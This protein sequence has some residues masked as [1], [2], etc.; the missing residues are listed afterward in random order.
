MSWH[1][2]LKLQLSYTS[3]GD[4]STD[5][6][7]TTVASVL[8]EYFKSPE[9]TIFWNDDLNVNVD[10]FEKLEGGFFATN[11]D[12]KVRSQS[13]GT[14]CISLQDSYRSCGSWWNC[15]FAIIQKSRTRSIVHGALLTIST[16]RKTRPLHLQILT[17]PKVKKSYS[18]FRSV[19]IVTANAFGLQMVRSDYPAIVLKTVFACIYLHDNYLFPRSSGLY[20]AVKILISFSG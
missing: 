6:I 18:F 4:T 3:S 2:S 8:S 15:S 14:G 16:K 13:T 11:W 9:R 20:R 17:T 5:Q 12:F 10:P 19:R 1:V 7:S